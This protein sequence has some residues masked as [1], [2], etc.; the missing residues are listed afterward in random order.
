MAFYTVTIED[1]FDGR[2]YTGDFEAIESSEAEFDA[3]QFYAYELDT[4]PD[5]IIIIS[6]IKK[7]S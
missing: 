2:Q 5:E 6:S 1:S 4:L 7:E 3:R